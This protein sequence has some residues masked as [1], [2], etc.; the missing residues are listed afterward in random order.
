MKRTRVVLQ[1]QLA[2]RFF[3]IVGCGFVVESEDGVGIDV[4]WAVVGFVLEGMIFGL[5]LVGLVVFLLSARH[6]L[7]SCEDQIGGFV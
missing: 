6:C 3:D 7:W 2:I 5:R 4:G 1:R